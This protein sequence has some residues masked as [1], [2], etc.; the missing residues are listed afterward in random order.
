MALKLRPLERVCDAYLEVVKKDPRA[1]T[2]DI[3]SEE[4]EVEIAAMEAG[5]FDLRRAI[6]SNVVFRVKDLISRVGLTAIK[7][8]VQALARES[9]TLIKSRQGRVSEQLVFIARFFGMLDSL[10]A[11]SFGQARETAKDSDRLSTG[12]FELAH[13]VD[14]QAR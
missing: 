14:V 9:D 10:A 4:L 1:N 6:T 7:A 12:G 11:S 13:L 3:L 2:W 8:G 5:D